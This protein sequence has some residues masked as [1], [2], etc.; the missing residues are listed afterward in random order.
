MMYIYMDRITGYQLRAA[1][2]PIAYDQKGVW[3]PAPTNFSSTFHTCFLKNNKPTILTHDEKEALTKQISCMERLESGNL[4]FDEAAQLITESF[5]PALGL[6]TEQTLAFLKAQ[7]VLAAKRKEEAFRAQGFDWFTGIVEGEERAIDE[8]AEQLGGWLYTFDITY[9][10]VHNL[11]ESAR[12]RIDNPKLSIKPEMVTFGEH[13]R[14]ERQYTLMMQSEFLFFVDRIKEYIRRSKECV[15]VFC[16]QI[17]TS[18]TIEQLMDIISPKDGI[19]A[20]DLDEAVAKV[21][22]AYIPPPTGWQNFLYSANK[23]LVHGLA[24]RRAR[25]QNQLTEEMKTMSYDELSALDD[26]KLSAAQHRFWTNLLQNTEMLEPLAQTVTAPE[27]TEP[28]AEG[29]EGAG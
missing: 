29:D 8:K 7:S 2:N 27:E 14:L 4:L 22:Y 6:Y 26:K 16:E 15:N 28:I 17:K 25:K 1:S 9:M 3:Y 5:N 23:W 18:R 12:V 20:L 19:S 10:S 21:H 13:K 11:S 24:I